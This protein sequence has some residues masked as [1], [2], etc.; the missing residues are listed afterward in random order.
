MMSRIASVVL[1]A[2]VAVYQVPALA[3]ED[4]LVVRTAARVNGFTLLST[5]ANNT[6][7]NVCIKSIA[8]PAAQRPFAPTLKA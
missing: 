5:A 3:E 1:V 6:G 8:S 7:A 2:T 4:P